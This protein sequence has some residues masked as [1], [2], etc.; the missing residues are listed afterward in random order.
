MP[1][2]VRSV[3]AGRR[4]PFPQPRRR[5]APRG[6]GQS[7]RPRAVARIPDFGPRPPP[8]RTV[9][10][11]CA[12]RRSSESGGVKLKGII[13]GGCLD[14]HRASGLTG[15]GLNSTVNLT[16]RRRAIR[17]WWNV[18][19]RCKMITASY[20]RHVRNLSRWQPQI[21]NASTPEEIIDILRRFNLDATADRLTDLRT[22]VE[23]DPE[24][25]PMEL[26]SLRSLATFLMSEIRERQLPEPE[27]GVTP[28]GLVEIAWSLPPPQWY[29]SHGLLALWT[30]SVHRHLCTGPTWSRAK[31]R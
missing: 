29:P 30:N 13:D 20:A 27:I 22:L 7:P 14:L 26:E 25:S 4:S 1:E 24:E 10:R 31:D 23:D 2:Y 21:E 16:P 5:P 17:R 28:D 9:D 19:E 15:I 8:R 3:F 12:S 11:P 6:L 18:R